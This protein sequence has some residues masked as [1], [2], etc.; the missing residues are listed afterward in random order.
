MCWNREASGPII[1]MFNFYFAAENLERLV[2]S[3][4]RLV[5]A[6]VLSKRNLVSAG[7]QKRFVSY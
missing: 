3:Q 4:R 6:G 5:V 7:G 1:R 2:P